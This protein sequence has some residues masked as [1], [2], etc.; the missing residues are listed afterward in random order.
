MFFV[1]RVKYLKNGEIKKSELMSYEDRNAAM[2]KFHTN[3]GTDMT[4]DSL[5]GSMCTVTN[6]HGGQEAKE[7]WGYTD[8]DPVPNAE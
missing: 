5:K 6:S 7:Y 1:T 3:L 2:A 8:I 4:D